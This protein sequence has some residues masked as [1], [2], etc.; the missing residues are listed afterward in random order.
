LGGVPNDFSR[1]PVKALDV[2]PYIKWYSLTFGQETIHPNVRRYLASFVWRPRITIL[3]TGAL[4]GVVLEVVGLRLNVL[5]LVRNSNAIRVEDPVALLLGFRE[6]EDCLV[7]S[8]E[9]QP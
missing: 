8:R 7:L 6:V 3:K 4:L 9:S 5:G 2:R 1:G